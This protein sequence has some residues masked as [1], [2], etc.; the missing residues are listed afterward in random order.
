M[1]DRYGNCRQFVK[2]GDCRRQTRGKCPFLHKKRKEDEA[3]SN[4]QHAAIIA[5]S[6]EKQKDA[7]E[8]TWSAVSADGAAKWIAKGKDMELKASDVS[9]PKLYP[10]LE[11]RGKTVSLE[12]AVKEAW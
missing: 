7:T 11:K 10:I 1:V 8:V 5:Y 6:E 9:R 2:H 12:E 3:I 4:E